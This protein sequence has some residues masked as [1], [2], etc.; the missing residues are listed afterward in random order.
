MLL[1]YRMHSYS[2]FWVASPQTFSGGFILCTPVK[3]IALR[4]PSPGPP[5]T[6]F[7]IR[8]RLRDKGR[9]WEHLPVHYPA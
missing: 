2:G 6:I 1:P 4:P 9:C 8:Y 5:S 3:D 7:W